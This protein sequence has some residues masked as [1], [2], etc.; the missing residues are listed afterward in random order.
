M[1]NSS[2][3]R[4]IFII[5]L[6]LLV[7]IG[8]INAAATDDKNPWDQLNESE[9]KW[10]LGKL[11]AELPNLLSDG[12]MKDYAEKIT[13]Y[14][15][16]TMST[17]LGEVSGGEYHNMMGYVATEGAKYLSEQFKNNLPEGYGKQI[18]TSL[19][20][21]SDKVLEI[22]R[23]MMDPNKNWQDV[24]TL[25]WNKTKEAVI[26]DLEATSQAAFTGFVD[27]ILGKGTGNLY[28]MAVQAEIVMIKAFEKRIVSESQ[29]NLY[30][31]YMENFSGPG[32]ESAAWEAINHL[33]V[34]A[35]RD[36]KAR[37][38]TAY[39]MAFRDFSEDQI[40]Q[41]F[42]A[43][44]N[45]NGGNFYSWLTAKQ[46]ARENAAYQKKKLEMQAAVQRVQAQHNK[47]YR[48]MQRILLAAIREKKGD[49]GKEEAENAL[50]ENQ[51]LL[52][53]IRNVGM[54]I[55][56]SCEIME[57]LDSEYITA[58]A[59]VNDAIKMESRLKSNNNPIV[60]Q[61]RTYAAGIEE[62]KGILSGI[63]GTLEP[64][65]RNSDVVI[66]NTAEGCGF[67]DEA[68]AATSEEDAKKALQSVIESIRIARQ[69]AE[70]VLSVNVEL[71][72]N[73]L[74]QKALKVAALKPEKPLNDVVYEFNEFLPKLAEAEEALKTCNDIA[75]K[76]GLYKK[77]NDTQRKSI[78]PWIASLASALQPYRYNEDVEMVLNEVRQIKSDIECYISVWDPISHKFDKN[79][80]I[81]AQQVHA[82]ETPASIIKQAEAVFGIIASVEVGLVMGEQCL[83]NTVLV[84]NDWIKK[85]KDAAPL[86]ITGYVLEN[87]NAADG[88]TVSCRG[89]TTV[90]SGAGEFT[91]SGFYGEPDEEFTVSASKLGRAG[92]A[93]AIYEGSDIGGITISLD[94]E[95]ETAF[96]L[97]GK[98]MQEG[99]PVEIATVSCQGITDATDGSGAFLLS[100]LSGKL[101]EQYDIAASK[102][103]LSG[104]GAVIYRGQS[105]SGIILVLPPADPDDLTVDEAVEE[106]SNEDSEQCDPAIIELHKTT[107]I[108]AG[109][110]ALSDYSKFN[111]S[112]SMARQEINRQASNP[113]DNSLIAQAIRSM[114]S[115]IGSHENIL[116]LIQ[117]MSADLLGRSDCPNMD[118]AISEIVSMRETAVS[119]NQDMISRLA[120]INGEL[121]SY[122]ADEE[123]IDEDG[124]SNTDDDSPSDF[125]KGGGTNE[126]I[127]GDS[128]DQDGDG[129][130]DEGFVAVAGKNVAIHVFD[131][132]NAKDDAFM[133]SVP[134]QIGGGTT[135]P[136]GGHYFYFRLAPGDYT[137]IVTVILAPDNVGTYTARIIHNGIVLKES[138]GS[139]KEGVGVTIQFHIE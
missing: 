13:S 21:H 57:G 52:G 103:N 53:Q 117:N 125:T 7:W 91:L 108:E 111:E 80:T 39:S 45:E 131:S 100:G 63:K 41:M 75:K 36:L 8:Y 11:Q 35:V 122:G 22:G 83:A 105:L 116:Q 23:A 50:K 28:I 138:S 126:E 104:G 101:D 137:A 56:R 115:A 33:T 110:Q 46:A 96:S 20:G 60:Q 25:A 129:E 86:S 66:D 120:A 61:W 24:S 43:C 98:V 18:Y 90:T 79:I 93:V 16:A 40:R 65:R 1:K 134:G 88:A 12:P 32:S 114:G 81:L 70:A 119:Q 130:Q 77:K 73:Q 112:Y 102:G 62:L 64:L 121:L 55:I 113:A 69:A 3:I 133:V 10:V 47:L 97:S 71:M 85:R 14:D 58:E 59:I 26:A 19:E 107:L 67:Y 82:N 48:D 29:N 37:N 2:L 6:L 127:P 54:L 94:D 27:H 15:I 49:K 92:S 68:R 118:I 34:G 51:V 99:N 136:G 31:K 89:A 76:S 78:K 95:A 84:V 38:E 123:N 9:K 132:G 124:Q 30:R 109:S 4:C 128:Y 135:D 42:A 44:A 139:P 74:S 17:L 5:G 106:I 72:Q 87:G